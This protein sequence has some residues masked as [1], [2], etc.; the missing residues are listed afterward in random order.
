MSGEFYK[1]LFNTMHEK[2]CK[3]KSKSEMKKIYKRF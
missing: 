2:E 1:D 3:D